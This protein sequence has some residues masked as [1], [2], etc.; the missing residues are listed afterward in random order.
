MSFDLAIDRICDH[1]VVEESVLI[2]NDQKTLVINRPLASLRSLRFKRNGFY[3]LSD[4][5]EYGFTVEKYEHPT[6]FLVDD[7]NQ[8]YIR[9]S[10]FQEKNLLLEEE[11]FVI[12]LEKVQSG[13]TISSSEYKE[14]IE[15]ANTKGFINLPIYDLSGNVDL[16]L[17]DAYLV[18]DIQNIATLNEALD[19]SL[20]A[21]IAD[22]ILKELGYQTQTSKYLQKE[23]AA[24][25]DVDISYFFNSDANMVQYTEDQ[26]EIFNKLLLSI[27]IFKTDRKNA[28]DNSLD[29]TE[30][31]THIT[32]RLAEI[33]SHFKAL[34]FRDTYLFAYVPR[35]EDIVAANQLKQI[36][37]NKK[38]KA[39]DDFYEV[40][41]L[42][43]A[44]HCPK[45]N[46]LRIHNDLSFTNK[47]YLTVENE[48]K[49]FQDVLKGTLT[50]LE[51]DPDNP[52]YGTVLR[53]L[54]GE[55]IVSLEELRLRISKSIQEFIT[56]L[57]D[58]QNQQAQLQNVTNRE[59]FFQILT[60]DVTVDE[61]NPTL[62]EINLIYRNREG[63]DQIFNRTI[64]LPQPL[65]LIGS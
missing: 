55:K 4:N 12:E 9:N 27:E 6:Q 15:L 38:Q 51:S 49:L 62:V 24:L 32:N 54:I 45:C 28:L 31:R 34:D 39:L 8:N 36:V 10:I 11:P 50:E 57:I 59:A 3:I 63:E 2:E 64:E 1:Y 35:I 48:A 23:G 42:T 19:T 43:V 65:N 5:T 25:V 21:T 47:D 16:V 53:S 17:L 13:A 22:Y 46:G 14:I 29:A 40:S 60:L 44:T 30:R 7:L 52:W 33:E 56:I 37:F 58:L 20:Q 41:Y 18:A 26:K 61:D